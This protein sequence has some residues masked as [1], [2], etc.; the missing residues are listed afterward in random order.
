MYRKHKL[1][2]ESTETEFNSFDQGIEEVV[3]PSEAMAALEF[4]E[5]EDDSFSHR[6]SST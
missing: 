6:A 4:Q 2:L 5:D 3:G 1:Y